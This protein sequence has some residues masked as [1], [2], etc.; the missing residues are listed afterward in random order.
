[1]ELFIFG[2]FHAREGC[3]AALGEAMQRVI[4]A[5]REEDGCLEVHGFRSVRDPRLLYL[6][7]HW[8]D[9]ASFEKHAQLPH[10]LEFLQEVESLIDCP[11]DVTRTE[12]FV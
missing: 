3:E 4:L 8:M 7:S 9:E 5:T 11:R 6:H 1:M 10:T 12:K 2:R